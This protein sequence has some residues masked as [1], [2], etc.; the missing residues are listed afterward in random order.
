MKNFVF[1]IAGIL[2]FLSCEKKKIEDHIGE[3]VFTADLTFDQMGDRRIVAGDSSFYMYAS[4]MEQDE[5]VIYR[6]HFGKDNNCIKDC[7]EYFAINIHFPM[8]SVDEGQASF[9][10][11]YGYY[12]SPVK[13][14]LHRFEVLNTPEGDQSQD[15]Y[16]WHIDQE[17][18]L[19]PS[20]L[21]S[22]FQNTQNQEVG[23]IYN[24]QE[25]VLVKFK[26]E[27]EPKA[28][29]CQ[30]EVR[31]VVN[32]NGEVFIRLKSD[33]PYLQAKW[34]TGEKGSIISYRPGVSDY[35]AKVI[36][37]HGCMTT[38]FVHFFKDG[39]A[40]DL[41][42]GFREKTI[43]VNIPGNLPM[44]VSIEYRTAEG[45]L[46]TSSRASQPG[47]SSFVIDSE[48]DFEQ[49]EL[50]IATKKLSANL[51]CILF[52]ENGQTIELQ[53]AEVVFAIGVR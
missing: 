52:G 5:E 4:Y 12:V 9:K 47:S 2:L 22:S 11:D 32:P 26:R 48:E 38:V 3:P 45:E 10:R 36:D 1:F 40:K 14:Y 13:G 44:S 16:S 33:T 51:N 24:D 30:L 53:E 29:D 41:N 20:L 15:F 25:S 28:V 31:F 43:P 7:E 27:T 18:E 17:V 21:I 37:G 50:G 23:L 6:G 49:N 42:V 34:N 8:H 46:Y 39:L 35:S 19:G